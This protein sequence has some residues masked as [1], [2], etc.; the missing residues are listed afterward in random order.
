MNEQT[1]PRQLPD[2]LSLAGTAAVV[3][4][5]GTHLGRAMATALGELGAAVHLVGRRSEVVSE[6]AEELRDRGI[7]A[8]SSPGDAADE[9]TMERIVDAVVERHGR[10]DTMVCNAGG[11]QG[12][13]HPPHVPTADLEATLR[14]NVTTTLVSAQA[15]ARLM[16]GQGGGAILTVGSIHGSLGSDKR[17]YTEGFRRSTAP[18]H[19]SKGA[20][21]NLTRE[22][23]CE[24]AEYGIRVNCISPGPIPKSNMD[25]ETAERIRHGVPLGRLGTPDDLKGAVALF[26]T[27]AGSWITGQNLYVDGGWT[28]W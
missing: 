27:G 20:V 18:Y 16:V 5:G 4:G 3:T 21:I 24:L 12:R 17:R 10:L 14:G 25:A 19:A 7:D 9:S 23:A 13:Q 6:A 26:A 2:W 11:A 8:T 28:A 15:A 1:T 22:L